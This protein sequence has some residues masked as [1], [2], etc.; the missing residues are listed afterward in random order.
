MPSDE[1][2]AAWASLFVANY[3]AGA[4]QDD[5]ADDGLTPAAREVLRAVDAGGVPAFVTNNLKQVARDN[6]IEVTPQWTP[7]EIVDALRHKARLAR[8][9]ADGSHGGAAG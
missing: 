1:D 4:G 7:N 8:E 2:F 9:Q 6:G 3:E 5:G